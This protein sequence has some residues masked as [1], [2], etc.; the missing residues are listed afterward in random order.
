M[1]IDYLAIALVSGS[2]VASV[3]LIILYFVCREK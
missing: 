3:I 1:T 2:F